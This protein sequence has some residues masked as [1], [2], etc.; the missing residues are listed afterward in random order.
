[1]QPGLS[2]LV[3]AGAFGWGK[4]NNHDNGCAGDM[5]GG[6][7]VGGP[8]I[9]SF[10]CCGGGDPISCKYWGTPVLHFRALLI[11]KPVVLEIT[12]EDQ[13]EKKARQTNCNPMRNFL[14]VSLI[15]VNKTSE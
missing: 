4:S 13:E 8:R 9:H 12:E 15:K 5:Q 3:Y 6:M 14:R 10:W 7:E 11:H 2:N 1:M